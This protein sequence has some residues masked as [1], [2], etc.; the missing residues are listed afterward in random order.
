M[1]TVVVHPRSLVGENE[2]YGTI[3]ILKS[4]ILRAALQL[5][6]LIYD[7]QCGL[8]RIWMSIPSS[9]ASTKHDAGHRSYRL[10]LQFRVL[11][12]RLHS[13]ACGHGSMARLDNVYMIV[14]Y[15]TWS[16]IVYNH[17]RA[18]IRT[19]KQLKLLERLTF[20]NRSMYGGTWDKR[21]WVLQI[22]HD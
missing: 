4:E 17:I 3:H 22:S 5:V 19:L 14:N 6:V 13:L 1:V 9:A 11:V 10:L 12:Q 7:Q 18:K 8:L 21:T 2:I 15:E 20:T 16:R